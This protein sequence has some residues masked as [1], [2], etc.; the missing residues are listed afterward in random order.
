MRHFA[1]REIALTVGVALYSEKGGK[2]TLQELPE[3]ELRSFA[4][5]DIVVQVEIL[6]DFEMAIVAA[7]TK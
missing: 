7:V 1:L 4:G 3:T 2:S 5:I 6:R